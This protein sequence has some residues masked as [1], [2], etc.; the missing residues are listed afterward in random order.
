MADER[1]NLS[2]DERVRRSVARSVGNFMLAVLVLAALGAWGYL[3]FY[4]LEPG[5]AA[6]IMRLGKHVATV[7]GTGLRWNLPPPIETRQIV[8]VSKIEREEFGFRGN[9][10]S[11]A[12]PAEL[13]EASMQTKGNNIVRVSFVVQ[14]RIKDAF[15]ARYR[16]ADPKAILRD[17]AQAAVR[18][19]VG[20][21]T[22]DAVL[23]EGRGEVEI[24]SEE[25]LQA[26][27]DG[28][29]AG[30]QVD[31]VQL[32]EVQPPA[33]VRAAF[34]DVVG[35][36]Q[37]ASRLVNQAEGYRNELLPRSRAQAAELL[38]SAA[39]YGEAKI[40]DAT[41]E[42]GRFDALAV[43]YLKAPEVTRRRLYLE[44]M[45][46]VLPDVEKVIVE[47]GVSSLVP[48]LPLG[49]RDAKVPR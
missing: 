49:L 33:Q 45:E 32:Q 27:L 4:Q 19:V 48:Y 5:Q 24:K 47:E 43:E 8:K 18:D 1:E 2:V 40:A 20:G 46:A 38:A 36:S 3:G 35:A 11:E 15:A 30:L 44:T 42:A 16:V 25:T 34:D 22:I 29:G 41:G 39:G 23:S 12:S 9:E 28:Y 14:Y 31:G 13:N 6:I 17:A 21:M 10:T 37:D 26:T 7:T